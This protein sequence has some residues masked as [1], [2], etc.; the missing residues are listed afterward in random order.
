MI[1]LRMIDSAKRRR[2]FAKG[3][4]TALMVALLAGCA[5]QGS[6]EDRTGSLLVTPGK[7]TLY[8]CPQLAVRGA[9]LKTRESELAVL[10]AK[11]GSGPGAAIAATLAYQTEYSQVR[12]ELDELTKETAAKHCP[13]PK[14]AAAPSPPKPK[15]GKSARG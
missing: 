10:M 8:S 4:V 2:A 11:A 1:R 12:G 5:A 7:Y 15:K 13:P 14:P 3:L 9:E 6:F